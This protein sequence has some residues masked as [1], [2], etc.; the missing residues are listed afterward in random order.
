MLRNLMNVPYP[1][2]AGNKKRL[3][4]FKR[5]SSRFIINWHFMKISHVFRH[6]QWRTQ[7]S[8]SWT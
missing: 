5:L 7:R 1:P 4:L 2:N 3:R 6:T 8:W